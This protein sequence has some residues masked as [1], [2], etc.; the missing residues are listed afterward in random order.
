MT[1]STLTLKEQLAIISLNRRGR[2]NINSFPHYGLA[3]A[4]LIELAE[5]EKIRLK[6]DKVILDNQKTTGDIAL[7]TA[8]GWLSKSSGPKKVKSWIS[9]M[10]MKQGKLK[11]LVRQVMMDKR[12]LYEDRKRF[13]G[14]IPYSIYYIKNLKLRRDLVDKL[15]R[16]IF[17]PSDDH[18][19]RIL[20]VLM[21]ASQIPGH[22]IKDSKLRRK[23]RKLFIT[24]KKE[25]IVGQA[26]DETVKAVQAVIAA[27]VAAST[28]VVAGN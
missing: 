10:G 12:V 21:F 2:S 24:M 18:E 1:Q 8:I 13:L 26:V 5:I 9:K 25:G 28:V 15:N 11:S 23:G 27:S 20:F 4:I 6:E 7:D 17:Q 22:V 16:F 14:I 3:G 19:L